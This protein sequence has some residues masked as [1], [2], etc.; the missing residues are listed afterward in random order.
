MVPDIETD[1]FDAIAGILTEKYDGI[2]IYS[3][4]VHVPEERLL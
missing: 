2:S 1:V 3:E 4:Y